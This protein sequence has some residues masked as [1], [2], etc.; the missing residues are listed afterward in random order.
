MNFVSIFNSLFF[1]QLVVLCVAVCAAQAG[2][3]PA[4]GA[5]G[6]G[7]HGLGYAGHGLHG[8]AVAAPVAIG[9]GHGHHGHD[10]DYYVSKSDLYWDC[11][12]YDY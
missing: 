1:F 4:H 11:I 7:G 3:V 10:V 8:Y 5:L 2:L 12:L 9:L 6:Y